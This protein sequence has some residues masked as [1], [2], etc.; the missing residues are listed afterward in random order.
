MLKAARHSDVCSACFPCLASVCSS[1]PFD[2]QTA[3][4]VFTRG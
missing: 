3:A 1:V 4:L 2:A